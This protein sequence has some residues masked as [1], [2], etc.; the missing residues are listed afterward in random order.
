MLENSLNVEAT[1]LGQAK[2]EGI[3]IGIE[4]GKRATHD[5]F[6]EQMKLSGIPQETIDAI[7]G[8]LK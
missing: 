2:N 5:A 7:V 1:A 4:I 6:I 8:R 3:E